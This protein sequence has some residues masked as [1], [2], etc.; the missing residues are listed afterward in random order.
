MCFNTCLH[1]KTTNYAFALCS[2]TYFEGYLQVEKKKR[3]HLNLCNS[4]ILCWC[5]VTSKIYE[6]CSQTAC[7]RVL[8]VL[9]RDVSSN[10]LPLSVIVSA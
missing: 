5:F 9:F 6:L 3:K 8:A 7:P 10:I 2:Q 1:E 4:I